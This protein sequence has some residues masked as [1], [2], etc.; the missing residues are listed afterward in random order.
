MKRTTSRLMIAAAV[1]AVASSAA[2]AQTMKADVPFA[3]RV[4]NQMYAAGT[5][6]F[7][8][9]NAERV[10]LVR[11]A[12][13]GRGGMQF[14][15]GRDS[16]DAR[17]QSANQPTVA[18]ECGLGRCQLT[19]I[20]SGYGQAALSLPHSRLRPNEVVSIRTIRL[21]PLNGD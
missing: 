12:D 4:G 3:F 5:Y 2:S 10:V 8:V 15:T 14:V 20:W 18:F 11:N 21:A 19:R 1:L 6:H 9:T 13:T 16:P 7:S 17:W